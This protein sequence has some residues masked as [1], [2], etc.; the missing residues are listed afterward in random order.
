MTERGWEVE[1]VRRHKE[2][3]MSLELM[4]AIA[5]TKEELEKVFVVWGKAPDENHGPSMFAF[6]TKAEA[7]A[8]KLGVH[9]AKWWSHA[10]VFDSEEEAEHYLEKRGGGND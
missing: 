7:W 1:S 5:K 9:Q 10:S 6:V 2:E 4:L 8:F 3:G